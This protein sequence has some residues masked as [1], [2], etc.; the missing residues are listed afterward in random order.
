MSMKNLRFFMALTASVL[1]MTFT[2]QAQDPLYVEGFENGWPESWQ[3]VLCETA[4]NS[5]QTSNCHSGAKSL[6][7]TQTG[8]GAAN[9]IVMPQLTGRNVT[10]LELNFWAKPSTGA[11]NVGALEVGYIT[12]ITDA[13][14][15][16]LVN[17][18]TYNDFYESY[19]TLYREK[20]VF[21]T[22]MPAG[23]RIA[24]RNTPT[25]NNRSWYLDDITVNGIYQCQKPINFAKTQL[26][27]TSVNL[28][29]TMRGESAPEFGDTTTV[30]TLTITD[31]SGVV[32]ANYP[33]FRATGPSFSH[34]VTGLQPN[35]TYT[36]K[37]SAECENNRGSSGDAIMTFTTFNA[38]LAL[39]YTENFNSMTTMPNEFNQNAS[40]NTSTSYVYQG[41]GKS[42]R[43]ASKTTADAYYVF[44][45][46]NA[47]L[48]NIQ[49][50][51]MV[52][53]GADYATT[54]Y[55]V[56][57][58]TDISDLSDAVQLYSGTADGAWSEA[59]FNTGTLTETAQPVLLLIRIEGRS[60][61]TNSTYFDNVKVMAIPSCLRP[62]DVSVDSIGAHGV[63]VSWTANATDSILVKA[64][65]AAD[66]TVVSAF[67]SSS[68]FVLTGL[69]DNTKYN[70][71]L[72]RYCSA[73]D[74]SEETL[75]ITVTTLCDAWASPL[76]SEDFNMVTGMPGEEIPSCWT[77]GWI[78]QVYPD[79][80]VTSPF[81]VSMDID[82]NA[83]DYNN[84]IMVLYP[85]DE[86]TVS[87]I[88]TNK[89]H[90]ENANQ[91]L[92]SIDVY[93][94][95]EFNWGMPNDYPN[96]G[97]ALWLTSAPGDTTGGTKLG[98]IHTLASE[99]PVENYEG[100]HTYE[101]I[102]NRT[103]D[104]YLTIVGFSE[105]YKMF[106][107]FDNLEIKA[108]PS[109]FP[110]N[111][112]A[113]DESTEG[114]VKLVWNQGISETQW[115]VDYTFKKGAVTVIDTVDTVS[116]R[117]ISFTNFEP[118][119]LYTI[120]G[121]I[122]SLCGEGETADAVPFQLSFTTPCEAI[123]T[124]PYVCG[125]E[126]TEI[127]PSTGGYMMPICWTRFDDCEVQE[128]ADPWSYDMYYNGYPYAESYAGNAH[129]GSYSLRFIT[130]VDYVDALGYNGSQYYA[131]N[132]YAV[133][134]AIDT[135][136]HPINTLMVSFYAKLAMSS[137]YTIYVGVMTDQNDTST[138]VATD[139]IEL[140]SKS[141]KFYQA[142]LTNYIGTGVYPAIYVKSPM[143][144]PAGTS[145]YVNIDD[146]TI[147]LAPT[148]PDIRGEITATGLSDSSIVVT[149]PDATAKTHWELAY[150]KVGE[151]SFSTI[152]VLDTLAYTFTTLDE[153]STYEFKA[154]KA[155]AADDHSAWTAIV[156]A[157]TYAVPATMPYVCGF[158]D[159]TENSKWQYEDGT[160]ET[161]RIGSNSNA[162]NSGEKAM[163]VTPDGGI[164][165]SY[166][167]GTL[168]FAYRPVHMESKKYN[169]TYN[170]K[171][172]GANSS[173]GFGKFVLLPKDYVLTPGGGTTSY[174]L[175]FPDTVAT[176][177]PADANG[178]HILNNVTRT[179]GTAAT[180]WQTASHDFDMTGKEGDY[181]LVIVWNCSSS[182]SKNQPPL[183]IDNISIQ[184]LT[185]EPAPLNT[186]TVTGISQNGATISI[187]QSGASNW[188]MI[189]DAQPISVAELP[190]NPLLRQTTTGPLSVT[191]LNAN[192]DY[193]YIAR[194]ICGEGDTS[195]WS[196]MGT[197]H[198]YCPSMAVPYS[199][200][201]EN[202]DNFTCWV[203][204]GE[205][206][207]VSRTSLQSHGGSYSMLVTNTSVSTP[208]LDTIS[209]AG[210]M[211]HGYAYS[212]ADSAR[213]TTGIFS[214]PSDVSTFED[215]AEIFIPRKQEWVEFYSF[216]DTLAS[217]NY[218]SPN[219]QFIGLSVV[220]ASIYFDD[221]E[222]IPLGSCMSPASP[223]IDN[224]TATSFDISFTAQSGQNAWVVRVN[225][226]EHLI[227]TNPA[228][229]TGLTGMTNYTVSIAT[230][231]GND[232][233][234]YV[235]CGTIKTGCDSIWLPYICG[236]EKE[237]GWTSTDPY[238]AGFEDNCWLSI[239][240]S[241][242]QPYASL[243]TTSN[244]RVS[245]QALYITSKSTSPHLFMI[246]PELKAPTNALDIQFAAKFENTSR[247][248]DLELGYMTDV[249]DTLTWVSILNSAKAVNYGV[250]NNHV[251][252]DTVAGVPANAR[253]AF[254][255]GP[256]KNTTSYYRAGLDNLLIKEIKSCSDPVSITV[257]DFS[258]HTA[259]VEISDTCASHD[260]Y[261]YVCGFYGFNPN[262]VTPQTVSDTT[263]FIIQNLNANASYQVYVRAACGAGDESNWV[264]ASFTTS[265]EPVTI[266]EANP[267][268][269]SFEDAVA[270][271][272]Y[273]N[274]CYEMQGQTS[275]YYIKGQDNT[276]YS[277]SQYIYSHTGERCLNFNVSKTGT[278]E[279]LS[280]MREFNLEAGK[281]YK[282]YG[283]AFTNASKN[284]FVEFLAGTTSQMWTMQTLNSIPISGKS[285]TSHT[286]S[287]KTYYDYTQCYEMVAGYFQPQTTGTYVIAVRCQS[288]DYG[289]VYFDDFTIEVS[290]DCVPTMFEVAQIGSNSINV[291]L[292]DTDNTHIWKYTVK[293]QTGDVV[294]QDTARQAAFT[295]SGLASASNYSISVSRICG[296]GNN[297]IDI[298]KL[299]KTTCG[300]MS[301][302]YVTS[303]ETSEGFIAMSYGYVENAVE[304]NCF[305]TLNMSSNGV[306]GHVTNSYASQ[307]SCSYGFT[308]YSMGE[309]DFPI[310]ILP[311][312]VEPAGRLLVE[313]KVQDYNGNSNITV[314]Y[315][316]N[317]NNAGSWVELTTLHKTGYS[318]QSFDVDL[319]E[320]DV[321]A[322]ARIAFTVKNL[323]YNDVFIDQL[324]VS[325][326]P[327][328]REPRSAAVIAGTTMTTI[329]AEVDMNGKPTA[330]VACFAYG[331]ENMVAAMQT[332]TGSVLFTSLTASTQY[333]VKYRYICNVGDTSAWSPVAHATTTATDCFAPQNV[334]I[335]GEVDAHNAT[336]TWGGAPDAVAYHYELRANGNL[337]DSA[338]ITNDT[339]SFAT[340]NPLTSYTFKV[341]T[342]CSDDTTAYTSKYFN[343]TAEV[344]DIPFVCD[345]EATTDAGKFLV[346]NQDV[347]QYGNGGVFT[348]GTAEHNG[349]GT[350]SMYFSEDYGTSASYISG[351]SSAEALINMPA[352]TYNISFDW[353][354]LGGGY[355][356]PEYP[357]YSYYYDYG[358]AFLAPSDY[359]ID[360]M[361]C[362][363]LDDSFISLMND[364]VYLLNSTSWTT[365]NVTVSIP[366][367][368]TYKLVFTFTC[369]EWDSYT[370]SL[371]IDNISI[372]A[373]EEGGCDTITT[374]PYYENFETIAAEDNEALE[375]N[376]WQKPLVTSLAAYAYADDNA[377][378][379]HGGT[380]GLNIYNGAVG[381]QEQILVM[382]EM[383]DINGMSLTLWHKAGSTAATNAQLMIGYY[384]EG[385]FTALNTAVRDINW[386][387]AE[388]IYNNIPDSS[389]MAF[390][391]D[392]LNS[393]YLD[394][395]RINRLV[396]GD[397]YFD[398]ICSGVDYTDHGFSK[399]AA[400]L[401]SGD[402]VF[403]RRTLSVT[404]GESDS[405]YTAHVYVHP[406]TSNDI[407]DTICANQPYVSGEWNI[408]SPRSTQPYTALP[409]YNQTFE[410]STGCTD[411]L[412]VLH[413]FI[414]PENVTLFDTICQGDAYQIGT[415]T[416][417]ES[418][419]YND[420]IVSVKGCPQVYT[421]NLLVVDSTDTTVVTI[422]AGESY[423]FEGQQYNQTGV[424]P[425]QTTGLNGCP[426]TRVLNLTV[427][428]T[429]TICN[430]SFCEGG[431]VMVDDTVITTAGT[432]EIHRLDAA[433]GCTMVY[434]ITATETPAVTTD[435]NDYI[436]EGERYSGYGLVDIEI[437]EDTM[438]TIRTRT[439]DNACD[440]VI[441]LH[442]A[443]VPT[444]Y[445]D[446]T[447][448]ISEGQSFTWHYNTY[449]LAGDYKDTIQTQGEYACDSV[450]TLH[451]IV[452]DG[453]ETVTS[454]KV[455][456]VPNPTS[457]GMTTYVY[458]DFDNLEQVVILNNFGQVV[459]TFK[460]ETYPIEI[461]GIQ[462]AGLYYIRLV[463]GSGNVYTEKLIVK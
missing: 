136:A 235:N 293:D 254:R 217:G 11:T 457:V 423:A 403:T 450:V 24:F 135:T 238:Y 241:S 363:E 117:E 244:Y 302:P 399:F 170:W 296:N 263:R 441:N 188:E 222:I 364:K 356:D 432:Y 256:A 95:P 71:T 57:Y 25:F 275:S 51:M 28:T 455:D 420:T 203:A 208:M 279:G 2:L 78:Y 13:S 405:I 161:L 308:G 294:M 134:P 140:D 416:H 58:I 391:I 49:M 460:P 407:Y 112:I 253:L 332:T 152:D 212:T 149:M 127:A 424:Y 361:A 381:T 286:E 52:T 59:R 331:T 90:V 118:A 223:V 304:G 389:R 132:L 37:I 88:S 443:Y 388:V 163:Y 121:T 397:E 359:T 145:E 285:Y 84:Q 219:A 277:S 333:D 31:A 297:S 243:T 248:G 115:I 435:I 309:D 111:G 249:N 7:I 396:V 105:A 144:E 36:A 280:I 185:C 268:H 213:F 320:Y 63:K 383:G 354:C 138:F 34:A 264:L 228:T 93:R 197:F 39:P 148:C 339:M 433:T 156:T 440:S 281:T 454:V 385:V 139:T 180:D 76:F 380:Q 273:A 413:L 269:D 439:A 436:C 401:Q 414:M 336:L 64:T 179:E 86:G 422:C 17:T 130:G 239:N 434:H 328:C 298:T 453:V 154:R 446:T 306:Y 458:G 334:R 142:L 48:N 283:Y 370:P 19:S 151:T 113:L 50:S 319:T 6:K 198:T 44:P 92:V 204:M 69:T 374:F 141:F 288:T 262:S 348:V 91:Y 274:N 192:S 65:S 207:N 166:S 196:Q 75:P 46:L 314:G 372:T 327:T 242:N 335:V 233:S 421:V 245:G 22:A 251:R 210:F 289:S 376:C 157:K 171:A 287:G 247:S 74:S 313:F 428:Q 312:F 195:L 258:A 26:T 307:G 104:M 387:Q 183:S 352:G 392:G 220:D 260:T 384:R 54:Q 14:S 99:S 109:C 371:C 4:N 417:T 129:T 357:E 272:A 382:P 27:D 12:D 146:L 418:G 124:L 311:D 326:C 266:T 172:N 85:Q 103:G 16:V 353:K 8:N 119:T 3:S 367:V 193:Y 10:G 122:S 89:F 451:L 97:L 100:W 20:T 21:L 231:C 261:E 143:Y 1:M 365:E 201:F 271:S 29:W 350:K 18:F 410:S 257:S 101:F 234:D 214:D 96:E 33:S 81:S 230:I 394:D 66:N 128:Y 47:T 368:E 459:D 292:D 177:E 337:V 189:V 341:R 45:L 53:T 402:N 232:T 120:S 448:T 340:L 80:Y 173:S 329:N 61:N 343:T 315:V 150:R 393:Y 322:G 42:L 447:A 379:V 369:S 351:T 114:T 158:E 449:T 168:T 5:V 174:F 178:Y 395:I 462:S 155:C 323:S 200:G 431:Q 167:Q 259:T 160:H 169:I 40:I 67:A 303:F 190:T 202:N 301:L 181:N 338:T 411:S 318:W 461:D 62:E 38:P 347:Y 456:V 229:I 162:V 73:N 375:A 324:K 429:D 310:L 400:E 211:V 123:S 225:E 227:T 246:L 43:L 176:F 94:Q 15:F 437:T 305:A 325:V 55:E 41:S 87:Y 186:F 250:V 221:I 316:T 430:V 159:D 300:Q 110:V 398:T 108:A 255:F 199:E 442:I 290:D 32:V 378:C 346:I 276:D 265:C 133:M 137:S 295:V 362:S 56:Y 182:A 452:V 427:A 240:N 164:S 278:Q 444:S 282:V 406:T 317:V 184:E 349:T 165:Y 194:T 30:F 236:F 23:A 70:V 126:S 445:G 409:P 360:D 205:G 102:V 366:E 125:F 408:Q 106:T 321:P 284:Q 147:D 98:F 187:G 404:T 209:L 252:T 226:Q 82:P 116:N 291:E 131:D 344:Y 267:F 412:V 377:S 175:A 386:A 419:I 224:I 463:T 425:V 330:E 415:Y 358:M 215:V 345:F 191:G 218:D 237:E 68:P 426:L 216:L 72:Q 299:F 373:V 60:G 35:T 390:R 9:Y 79:P 153:A 438:I 83:Y 355:E 206:S 270:G 107:G 342:Y 77:S